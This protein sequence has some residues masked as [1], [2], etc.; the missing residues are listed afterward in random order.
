MLLYVLTSRSG[1]ELMATLW[2]WSDGC[3]RPTPSATIVLAGTGEQAVVGSRSAS[4]APLGRARSTVRRR[5]VD[6]PDGPGVGA[7][8]ELAIDWKTANER[9]IT[10]LHRIYFAKLI[11]K[12]PCPRILACISQERRGL[13]KLVLAVKDLGEHQL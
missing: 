1:R 9:L 11:I 6:A 4:D 5:V 8:S 10:Q 2:A 12:C 13:F 7:S 3:L